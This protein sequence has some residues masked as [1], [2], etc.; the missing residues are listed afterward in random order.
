MV[1]GVDL[2]DVIRDYSGQFASYFKKVID[3]SYDI[4]NIDFYTHEFRWVFPFKSNKQYEDFTYVDCA[5]E[6]YGCAQPMHKAL[7]A[8]FNSW[9]QNDLANMDFEVPQVIIVSPFEFG[10]TIQSSLFFL[11]KNGFRAREYYFPKVSSTIWDKADIVI[12]AN[13]ILLGNKPNDEKKVSVK[14]DY[15]YNK[16][17]EANFHYPS[18]MELLNNNEG[19]KSILV[20]YHNKFE[21]EKEE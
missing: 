13:P 19:I 16:E 18:L 6:I 3:P 4:D 20:D 1:I 15:M 11:S 14:I 5:Y 10:L 7:M 21:K 8:R 17:A 2:N 12:T 9:I